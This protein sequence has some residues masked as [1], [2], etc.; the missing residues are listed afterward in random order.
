M[1]TP[2]LKFG[3]FFQEPF[4]S[5]SSLGT[6]LS[7]DDQLAFFLFQILA[8]TRHAN[9]TQNA[10]SVPMANRPVSVPLLAH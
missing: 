2:F 1:L 9:S 10:K 6:Q 3:W 7:L 8:K 4:L 5:Q